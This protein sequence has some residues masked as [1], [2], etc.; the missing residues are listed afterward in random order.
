MKSISLYEKGAK[1]AL[2]AVFQILKKNKDDF[3]NFKI[4]FIKFQAINEVSVEDL[5]LKHIEKQ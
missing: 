1:D 5:I 4:E 2:E 3:E